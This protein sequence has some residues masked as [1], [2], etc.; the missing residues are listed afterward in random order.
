[1]ETPNTVPRTPRRL[2]HGTDCSKEEH[3]TKQSF[4]KQ[5]DINTVLA[6]AQTGAGLSHLANYGSIYGDFSHWNERTYE[7]MQKDLALGQT[8]FNDLPAEL[9]AEFDHNPGKFF[10]VVNTKT[11][12]EL[13]ELFPILAQPG[14]QF[15]DVLGTI[16]NTVQKAVAAAATDAPSETDTP[17]ETPEQG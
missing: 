11:P 5:C 12:E 16:A 6:R 4:K 7:D 2:K 9:R 10:E 3:L 14:L 15:P 8:I 1:M 13:E 17:E